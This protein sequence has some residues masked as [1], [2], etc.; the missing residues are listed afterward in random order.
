VIDRRQ[1]ATP[2]ER[3][4]A[5]TPRERM[6][7]R[8]APTPRVLPAR[9]IGVGDDEA[10][11]PRRRP[12]P[13]RAEPPRSEAWSR[14][15]PPPPRTSSVPP[16]GDRESGAK[17]DVRGLS[18]EAAGSDPAPPSPAL[19][20][21]GGGSEERIPAAPALPTGLAS[22]IDGSRDEAIE[23]VAEPARPP[24]PLAVAATAFFERGDDAVSSTLVKAGVDGARALVRARAGRSLEPRMRT[25]FVSLLR[26]MGG[27]ALPALG[28]GLER[29]LLGRDEASAEDLLRAVPDTP[30]AP[31]GTIVAR[32]GAHAS[33]LLRKV[34]LAAV[35]GL[36]GAQAA[37]KLRGALADGDESVRRTAVVALRRLG[38]TDAQTAIELAKIVC[39]DV[40]APL[41]LRVIAAAALGNPD[42]GARPLCIGALRRVV[43][44]PPRTLL[45]RVFRKDASDEPLLVAACRSLL[46][47]GGDEAQRAVES[48]LESSHGSL[49]RNL[50][51][52]MRS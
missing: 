34:A 41:E 40:A 38:A 26:G 37:S 32:Y 11:E 5:P 44:P 15:D 25:L 6:P 3:R 33:P 46:Q 47:I 27:E 10:R 29:A 49:R 28:V 51:S 21:P 13:P 2:I 19:P 4:Q 22:G 17:R 48:R 8:Q 43:D 45:E 20:P 12:E 9:E 36:L 42:A 24:E 18:E 31:L 30:N 23:V 39:G 35:G 52:V 7:R 16:P 1:A 50:R 14:S